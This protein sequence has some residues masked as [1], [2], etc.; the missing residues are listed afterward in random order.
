MTL[1]YFYPPEYDHRSECENEEYYKCPD[2]NDLIHEKYLNYC[3]GR[4]IPRPDECTCD[5]IPYYKTWY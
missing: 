4:F 2:C 1:S 5:E 3:C